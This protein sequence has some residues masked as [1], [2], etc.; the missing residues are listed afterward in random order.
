MT[1][2][3][4][5][6]TSHIQQS[7]VCKIPFLYSFENKFFKNVSAVIPLHLLEVTFGEGSVNRISD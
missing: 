3:V 1:K 5:I 7:E 4:K 6:E 2:F